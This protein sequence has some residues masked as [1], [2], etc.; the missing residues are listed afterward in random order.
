VA[1]DTK[2]AVNTVNKAIKTIR[3]FGMEGEVE[4]VE[5][6]KDYTIQIVIPKNIVEVAPKTS[7]SVLDTTDYKGDTLKTLLDDRSNRVPKA[8]VEG[9]KL[10]PSI[11]IEAKTEDTQTKPLVLDFDLT[12]EIEYKLP[13]ASSFPSLKTDDFE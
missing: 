11:N 8:V 3:E 10:E 5:N 13:E 1:K 7:S 4:Q 12:S 2:L 9:Q 6:E